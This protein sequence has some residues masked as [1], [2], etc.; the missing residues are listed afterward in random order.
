MFKMK[1][2]ATAAALAL[3]APAAQ[4]VTITDTFNVVV[5]SN[6][7]LPGSTP[8]T[9]YV[10]DTGT[11]SVTYTSDTPFGIVDM[12]ALSLT[13]LGQTFTLADELF[14]GA[15]GVQLDASG[16]GIDTLF[17]TFLDDDT[18]TLPVEDNIAAA[19]VIDFSI[20]STFSVSGDLQTVTLEVQTVEVA[21]VPIPAALP[22]S[23]LALGAM[24]WVGRRRA[25][26]SEA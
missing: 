12:D 25:L 15:F 1:L 26:R 20:S 9:A 22:L 13:I 5:G 6:N 19:G 18:F 4:A 16:A 21:P 3:M 14:G 24:G 2:A 11:G 7:V 10:G 17:A 8:G 23:M